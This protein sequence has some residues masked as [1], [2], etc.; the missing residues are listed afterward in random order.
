[1]P[2]DTRAL[3]RMALRTAPDSVS[4]VF[5][6]VTEPGVFNDDERI[7]D[8]GTGEP[9]SVRT[10]EVFVVRDAFP[11]LADG[12]TVT[13]AGVSYAVRGRPFPRENGDLWAIAVARLDT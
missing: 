8:D 13:I 2:M 9:V 10:R 4:V 1:M 3:A 7:A 6:S 5:G 11:G 12:S